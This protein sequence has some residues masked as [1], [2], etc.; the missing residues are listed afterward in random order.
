[1]VARGNSL[2]AQVLVRGIERG[3]FRPVY[4]AVMT[5]VLI[6]PVLT[7]MMWTHSFMPT[8]AMPP[9]DPHAFMETFIDVSLRGLVA[10]A[11]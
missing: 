3:E 5:Q 10:P 8:C 4:P 2:I 1:M 7:L 9:I 6:A 11:S